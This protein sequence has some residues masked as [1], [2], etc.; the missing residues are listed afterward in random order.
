MNAN[1]I[2]KIDRDLY[3]KNRAR[4][5]QDNIVN[6]RESSTCTSGVYIWTY[7]HTACDVISVITTTIPIKHGAMNDIKFHNK[8]MKRIR[9][10]QQKSKSKNVSAD[11]EGSP[12]EQGQVFDIEKARRKMSLLLKEEKKSFMSKLQTSRY[13]RT[14]VENT[15]AMIIQR[16]V[17][18]YSTRFNMEKIKEMCL[19]TKRVRSFIRSKLETVEEFDRLA[20]SYGTHRLQYGT[21]RSSA[22]KLIQCAWRQSLSFKA[23]S[24]KRMDSHLLLRHSAATIIQC[25]SRCKSSKVKVSLRRTRIRVSLVKNSVCV[26]QRSIRCLIARRVV[27]RRRY[28]LRYVAAIMIQCAFR[29]RKA[30]KVLYVYRLAVRSKKEYR[31]AM[32]FQCLIRRFFAKRRII[33]MKLRRLFLKLNKAVSKI[34]AVVRG[35]LSRIRVKILKQLQ[36]ESEFK[37]ATSFVKEQDIRNLE[38]EKDLLES[39]DIFSQ[40]KLGNLTDVDDIFHGRISD[41]H[42]VTE[43][44][45]NGDN[46]LTIAVG[47]GNIEFVRKC[48]QW[49]FDVNHRNVLDLSPLMIAVKGN[50]LDIIQ[51]ILLMSANAEKEEYSDAE[52]EKAVVYVPLDPISRNDAAY[53]LIAATEHASNSRSVGY[54]VLKLLIVHGITIE[55]FDEN[56]MTAVHSACEM[57]HVDALELL[58]K[59]ST[60]VITLADVD[61]LGQ[62]SLHKAATSSLA[63]LKVIL[64]IDHRCGIVLEDHDRYNNLIELDGDG[65]DALLLAH[66]AGKHEIAEFIADYLIQFN[67]ERIV[68]E[69]AW[70][71]NDIAKVIQL[72]KKSDLKSLTFLIEAGVDPSWEEEET[73]YSMSM[74]A[75]FVG[76][77]DI[78]ELLLSKSP[79]LTAVDKKGWTIIHH[80]A[81]FKDEN[82]IP[83]L[84]THRYAAACNLT[85]KSIC[86]LNEDNDTPIHIAAARNINISIDLLAKKEI[87]MAFKIRN[88]LGLTPL[89]VACSYINEKL[90]KSYLNQDADPTVVD[91]KGN[92]CIWHLY[93]PHE[94]VI[95][96]GRKTIASEWLSRSPKSDKMIRARASKT[97]HD[98]SIERE[99]EAKQLSAEIE[100][101]LTFVRLGCLYNKSQKDLTLEELLN[102]KSDPKVAWRNLVN[103][104]E[105]V[106]NCDIAIQEKSYTLL[107]A[108]PNVCTPQDMFRTL[109]SSFRHDPTGHAFDALVIGGVIEVLI[110]SHLHKEAIILK[111][112]SDFH[113]SK[114]VSTN[115]STKSSIDTDYRS[116]SGYHQSTITSNSMDSSFNISSRTDLETNTGTTMGGGN[117]KELENRLFGD[118]SLLAWSIRLNN[119]KTFKKIMNISNGNSMFDNYGNTGL[120]FVSRYGTKE[121][122]DVMLRKSKGLRYEELNCYGRTPAME[123]A[124]GSNYHCMKKLVSLGANVRRALDGKY[125]AWILV[126]ARRRELQEKNLQ[127]GVIGDDDYKWH[128]MGILPY[129]LIHYSPN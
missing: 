114:N 88:N 44:D 72:I 22:T 27:R 51:Y 2:D 33:R 55:F 127:T 58:Y 71:Y 63:T 107:K 93:H 80:A 1:V 77:L 54:T 41:A 109:L 12:L 52:S 120:H 96:K 112:W 70:T 7:R 10:P 91:F 122:F 13:I 118:F 67:I 47:L 90:I 15:A 37:K 17:R 105:E 102:M 19:I 97:A 6:V 92:N 104:A 30:Q 65:K 81:T 29:Y 9:A 129:Y 124:I 68:D 99:Q 35:F 87:E 89:L 75:A 106:E 119:F 4:R 74:I 78:L 108:L 42:D 18:G 111:S 103:S 32:S 39:V 34:E 116:F 16:F 3:I 8:E 62:N 50:H 61:E 76:R 83:S 101:I 64:G 36:V 85:V 25:M 21:S 46:L 123:A 82:I 66:L 31:G 11:I 69:V 24:R 23:L 53:I 113:Q 20:L 128:S 43:I 45:A 5:N 98:L 117:I 100:L 14:T 28:R 49:G 57:G 59:K 95:S 38:I 56:G 26:I 126:L 125:Y 94:S 60:S 79:D 73:Q 121:M 84:L 48:I 110:N 40:A 115:L 86:E